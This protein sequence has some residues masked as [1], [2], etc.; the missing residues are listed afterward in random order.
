M[1]KS[2]TDKKYHE[3][4]KAPAVAEAMAGRRKNEST[5]R[6]MPTSGGPLWRGRQDLHVIFRGGQF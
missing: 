5:R 4:G 1:P 6:R 2:K 3:K